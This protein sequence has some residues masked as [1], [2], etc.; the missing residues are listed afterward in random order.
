MGWSTGSGH[1]SFKD[2]VLE[3]FFSTA[4]NPC[5]KERT[6][7]TSLFDTVGSLA[8]L[9]VTKFIYAKRDITRIDQKRLNLT[10]NERVSVKRSVYPQAHLKGLGQPLRDLSCPSP[11]RSITGSP[12]VTLD[13]DWSQKRQVK[14]HALVNFDHDNVESVECNANVWW[15]TPNASAYKIRSFGVA[16]IGTVLLS[17]T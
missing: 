17:T 15:S 9:G 5:M 8:S 2:M 6:A 4:L 14:A 7:G 3:S 13:D 12:A 10:M 1:Q 16:A 11:G